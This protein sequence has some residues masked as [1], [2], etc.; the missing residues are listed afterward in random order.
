LINEQGTDFLSGHTESMKQIIIQRETSNVKHSTSAKPGS[1][2]QVK[3]RK[4]APFKLYG[5]II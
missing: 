1:F 5:E 2:V 4:A 3:I